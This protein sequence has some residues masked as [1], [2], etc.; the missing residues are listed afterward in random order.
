MDR[1]AMPIYL[2]VLCSV[3]AT[4]SAM[5]LAVVIVPWFIRQAKARIAAQEEFTKAIKDLSRVADILATVPKMIAG[6]AAAAGAM[7]SEVGK[8]REAVET[9]VSTVLRPDAKE[10]DEG[11]FVA[12]A[13]EADAD[14]LFLIAQKWA[15][16]PDKDAEIIE[17][18]ADDELAR[19]A[20]MP[21][22]SME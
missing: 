8:M 2:V 20:G 15:E 11:S 13:N 16:N 5:T 7:A 9:F 12:P 6:H 1:K 17:Q 4:A 3:F 18:M 21:N 22:I 19:R 14:K 10:K